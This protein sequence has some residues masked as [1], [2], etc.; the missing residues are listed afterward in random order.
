MKMEVVISSAA[1]GDIEEIRGTLIASD[2]SL[3]EQFH[4]DVLQT[5]HY[6]A[7]FPGGVQVR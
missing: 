2:L 6:I 1:E 4:Q 5:L 7:Q 3:G